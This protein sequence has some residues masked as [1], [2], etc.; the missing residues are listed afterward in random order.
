MRK[1]HRDD[2]DNLLGKK[3]GTGHYFRKV[4]KVDRTINPRLRGTDITTAGF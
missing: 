2:R 4:Q 3:E 1:E